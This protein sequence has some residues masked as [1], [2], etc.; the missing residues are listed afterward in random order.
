MEHYK[1]LIYP[2]LMGNKSV[3]CY[4][5]FFSLLDFVRALANPFIIKAVG[6]RLYT[7]LPNELSVMR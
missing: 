3:L 4:A 6:V 2:E 5:N 1:T 7:S